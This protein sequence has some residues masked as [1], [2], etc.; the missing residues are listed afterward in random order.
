MRPPPLLM[1][2]LK[3]WSGYSAGN[4]GDRRITTVA[5]V[6]SAV[7]LKSFPGR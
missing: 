4:A 2:L 3:A 1:L 7:H 6:N 5:M